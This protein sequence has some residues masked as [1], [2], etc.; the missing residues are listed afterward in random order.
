MTRLGVIL[1]LCAATAPALAEVRPTP[2]SGDPRIQ[3]IL[4]D[5][6]QVIQLQVAPGYQLT[7]EFG[8]DERIEN[9]AVGDSGAWQVTPNKRGDHLFIKA[10]QNGVTTNMTVVTE[11]R[12]YSFS[13]TPAYGSTPDL[14]FTVR[15]RFPPPAVATVE[16]GNGTVPEI[17]RYKFSG[18]RTLRP[19]AID[20][21][22]IHTY[23]EWPSGATMPAVFAIGSDGRETLVNGMMREHRYVIDSISNRLVFRLDA[24]TAYATRIRR[25]SH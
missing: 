16:P 14:P 10:A 3:T 18:A 15:V 4:Y 6:D 20:D 12:T 1:L 24:R 7:L 21:D 23:L 2:G 17:G 11:A 8:P 19:S 5:P 22:G 25:K 9:V 13:L